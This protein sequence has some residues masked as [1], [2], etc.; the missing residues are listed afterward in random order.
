MR[1]GEF[2]QKHNITQDTIRYYLDMGLL[3]TKKK[4]GQYK[5]S[6][7]DS[8]DLERIMEL[9]QLEFSL[10]EIQ[11]ILMFQRLSGTNTDAFHN[12]YIPFLE[13]KQKQI[14]NEIIKY[15]EMNK[16]VSNKIN[17]I[18]IQK[19]KERKKIGFQMNSLNILSCPI[20]ASTLKVL[21]GTIEQNM[22]MDAD[23]QCECGYKAI[24]ENGIYVDETTVRTKT[25]NGK[26]MVTKEEYLASCSHTYVNFL[27]KGM[28]TL[29]EYINKYKKQPEYIIELDNCI[30]FFLLQYIK[31]IPKNSTYILIDY[32][33]DRIVDLKRNLEMYYNHNNF[34]FLCC[35][36]DRLPIKKM[37]IDV[38]VDFW[39][40]K[41]YSETNNEFLPDKVLNVLKND[42][43]FASVF[44]YTKQNSKNNLKFSNNIKDNFTRENV[45]N[46]LNLS[47]LVEIDITDMDSVNRETPY[48]DAT[49][50]KEVYQAV[51]VGKKTSN[52][53]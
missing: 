37:S 8:R 49:N 39:M 36:F 46:K 3:V 4:G 7:A 10:T 29:I 50:N 1:I 27:Y 20:C 17:Q 5:F 38:M 47:N 18:K 48:N 16:F 11:K 24:I 31:Y 22:I 25:V 21:G 32:D 30:G 33:K 40:T 53:E 6:E 52:A 35:D 14:T 44:P 45:L 41:M 43:I 12:L 42:G 23:I 51:Y 9:K 19:S 28:T 15:N 2:A 13:E 34:I 26:K